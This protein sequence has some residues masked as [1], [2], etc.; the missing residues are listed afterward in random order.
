M[1][2]TPIIA[3]ATSAVPPAAAAGIAYASRASGVACAVSTTR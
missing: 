3:N 1:L 2:I